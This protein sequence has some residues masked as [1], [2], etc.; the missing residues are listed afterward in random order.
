[1]NAFDLSWDVTIAFEIHLVLPQ[2]DQ[3]K[4]ISN[5]FILSTSCDCPICTMLFHGHFL[6][7]YL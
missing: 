4:E 1:M 7:K 5:L 3:P 6:A 2:T